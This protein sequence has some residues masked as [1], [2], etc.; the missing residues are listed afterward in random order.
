MFQKKIVEAIEKSDFESIF[1]QSHIA[2]E[3]EKLNALKE[4][5]FI[6][7]TIP[8]TTNHSSIFMTVMRIY[9]NC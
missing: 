5:C 4:V 8:M 3:S 1:I 9:R 2:S 6:I 7:M